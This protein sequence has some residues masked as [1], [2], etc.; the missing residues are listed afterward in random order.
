MAPEE[1]AD[2]LYDFLYRDSGRITSYYAQIFGGILSSLEENASERSA[3]EKGAEANAAVAK[4]G[5]KHTG[6][7]V[8]SSKRLLNPH[9]VI[10]IDVLS[11]LVDKGKI[12]GAIEDAEH[13]SLVLTK[14]T[15]IFVDRSMVELA[16]VSFSLMI[17]EEERKPPKQRNHVEIQTLKTVTSFLSKL[18]LP[19]AFLL[20]TDEGLQVAGTI[21]DEGMEEPIGSYYYK[22]GSA[23]LADVY[24]IGIKEIPSPAFA[25]EGN[26]MMGAGKAA[27]Q[28]LSNMLFP[29]DALRVTPIAL[30]RKLE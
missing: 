10:T 7:T 24:L 26:Q 28:L 15:L 3:V 30:F 19:S 1:P 27:A 16:G 12:G 22:H 21:K 23:G 17:A 11:H 18:S 20:Q 29:D 6:E 14:G 5:V 9:D 4:G 25:M 8:T 13:G 2:A